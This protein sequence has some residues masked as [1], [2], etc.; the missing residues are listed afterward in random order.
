[1]K[2]LAKKKFLD[3][4]TRDINKGKNN[5]HAIWFDLDLTIVAIYGDISNLKERRFKINKMSNKQ[6]IDIQRKLR[7]IE[8]TIHSLPHEL[9]YDNYEKTKIR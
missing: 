3:K 1:M 8:K 6:M 2:K 5:K 7:K 4:L 9:V